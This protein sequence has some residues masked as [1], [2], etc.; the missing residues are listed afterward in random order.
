MAPIGLRTDVTVLF[1]FT[2]TVTRKHS[3]QLTQAYFNFMK[4]QKK[5]GSL[6]KPDQEKSID[7]EKFIARYFSSVAR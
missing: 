6:S 5:R 7:K 2:K 4:T 3:F 1:S